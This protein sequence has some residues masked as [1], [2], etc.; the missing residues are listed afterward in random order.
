MAT[1]CSYPGCKAVLPPSK[2]GGRPPKWCPEHRHKRPHRRTNKPQ[3]ARP[4]LRVVPGSPEPGTPPPDAPPAV[5]VEGGDDRPG[6]AVPDP[7]AAPG[8]IATGVAGV[9]AALRAGANPA[10]PAL[11]AYLEE[12]ALLLDNQA[13]RSDP[14]V[15]VGVG[16]ELRAALDQ[17]TAPAVKGEGAD[18]RDPW[19][20]GDLRPAVGDATST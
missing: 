10:A 12:L 6:A 11:R 4:L 14:R 2:R 7:P 19:G 17:L 20:F 5:L 8:A 15:F 3:A 9:L 18:D 1:V 13:T 16:R